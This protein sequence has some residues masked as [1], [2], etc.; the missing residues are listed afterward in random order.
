MLLESIKKKHTIIYKK[1]KEKKMK[2]NF[3]MLFITM[4][5][6]S[7]IS[8]TGFAEEKGDDF[9]T[10]YENLQKDL[11]TK[12]AAVK[13]RK[14]YNE[15]RKFQSESL[16][17]LLIKIEKRDGVEGKSFL[18]GKILFD[19]GK[20]DDAL[21][22]FDNHIS[23]NSEFSL[24]AK[25]YKVKILQRKEKNNDALVIFNEIESKLKPSAKLI[26]VLMN[27]AFSLEDEN[28][29]AKYAKNLI[30][31][32]GDK[33]EFQNNKAYMFELLA[34]IEKD[35]G[36]LKKAIQILENGLKQVKGDRAVKS[37]KSTINQL[38]L[39]G[40]PAIELTAKNWINSKEFS[41]KDMKGKVVV[42][43]FW[44]PWCGPCRKV[45]PTL[46]KSYNENSKK[47]LVVLGYTK[48]YGMYSD[49][50]GS[51][52]KVAPDEEKKLI[53]GFVDRLAIKYPVAISESKNAFEGYFV[54]GIPTM[55]LINKE[56][57]ITE[58]TVGSGDE[59]KLEEK[60]NELLK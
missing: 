39:I 60:I 26:D 9:K 19:I 58:I 53:K 5:Y 12:R 21:A 34:N 6:I 57:I 46:I 1:I 56:G 48:L 47:G 41:L 20:Y 13:S 55:V 33:K 28:L 15:Y 29:R 59:K 14:A 10:A 30:K 24:K 44:A 4:F 51:K 7:L 3:I 2:K 25:F 52:G 23:K 38:K 49:E 35:K 43:D 50:Q 54:A 11:K 42:I 22:I 16:K 37:M 17:G 18:K 40:K 32:A 36:D 45:I 31:I 8:T 27:F